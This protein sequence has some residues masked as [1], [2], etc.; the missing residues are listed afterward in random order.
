[1]SQITEIVQAIGNI[2]VGSLSEVPTIFKLDN[3]KKSVATTPARVIFPMQ[4]GDNEG[5]DM[6]YISLGNLATIT[7]VLAD[8][9]LYTPVK[10]GS[11]LQGALPEL[12]AYV[13]NYVDAFRTQRKLG[14]THVTIENI[15]YEWNQFIFPEQ[16][17]GERQKK[18]V[19]EYYGVLMTLS[20][21]EIL[22]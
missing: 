2:E 16:P 18:P 21:K 9:M 7:W 5:R 6:N 15:D 3:A 17:R 20:I 4:S 13:G 14:L 12:V 22:T 1:M 10:E 11:T 8:L 19:N